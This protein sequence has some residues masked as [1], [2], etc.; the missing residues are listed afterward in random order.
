MENILNELSWKKQHTKNEILLWKK[1]IQELLEI[2]SH[3]VQ[4]IY[5]LKKSTKIA[6]LFFKWKKYFFSIDELKKLLRLNEIW[7]KLSKQ[8]D[9]LKIHSHFYWHAWYVAKQLF[10]KTSHILYAN[11]CLKY[12][13]KAL[14][15]YKNNIKYKIQI[16]SNIINLWKNFFNLK[17]KDKKLF[18]KWCK[19]TIKTVKT[20]LKINEQYPNLLSKEKIDE[21]KIF[22]IYIEN[23]LKD[24]YLLKT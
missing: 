19:I 13:N 1:I 6:F 22:Y 24:L 20:Q 15:T 7:I 18:K 17:H 2:K 14:E 10:K 16:N 23:I 8:I 12:S 9:D 4:N 3:E 5:I 21:L 11:K